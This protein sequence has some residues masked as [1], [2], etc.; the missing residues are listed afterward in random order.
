VT[1][2][3]TTNRPLL[4]SGRGVDTGLSLG[5]GRGLA[6]GRGETIGRGGGGIM[7]LGRGRG[8]PV[9]QQQ[10]EEEEEEE[11][12]QDEAQDEEVE[13]S[14][15][16]EMS[17]SQQ[18]LV[19]NNNSIDSEMDG[20][21][22]S[23]FAQALIYPLHR[24]NPER[25]VHRFFKRQSSKLV[26]LTTSKEQ[27]Q[28]AFNEPSPDDIVIS[29]GKATTSKQ[30]ENEPFKPIVKQQPKPQK[31]RKEKEEPLPEEPTTPTTPRT[32][33]PKTK[34]APP[35][36]QDTKQRINIVIIGHVDAGKSTLMGHLL[37]QSGSVDDKVI[38]KYKKESQQ[39]G[40]SSFHYAWVMD[41]NQE[42]RQ[43]GITMDVGVKHFETERKRVTILDAPGHRD[44]IPKMIT[45]AVQADLAILVVGST[46]G[47]FEAG[48]KDGGQTREHLILVRSLGVSQI[49]I[50]VNKM[51]SVD[52]SQ[53]RFDQ[54]K[55]EL[56]VFLKQIGLTDASFVPVSG[57]VGDNLYTR[58]DK[59]TW[60]DGPSLLE[61]IDAF[62]VPRDELDHQKPVRMSISDVYKSMQTG[63]TVSG[64][65][66]SGVLMVNQQVLLVP[67]KAVCNVKSITR[68][69]GN[70]VQ[71]AYTGD[72]VEVGLTSS[73]FELET[74]LSAGQILCD[75]DKPI[76]M[77]NR[78]VGRVI[79][80]DLDIPITK[81]SQV[82][83]HLQHMDV[84]AVVTKLVSTLNR[85]LEVIKKK[86]RVVTKNS[87]AI[88]ELTVVDY[89]VCIELYSDYKN[90]G[91]FMLRMGSKTVAAGIVT[92]LKKIKKA[93]AR[94]V[95]K[96][97]TTA[98]T[99]APLESKIIDD[100]QDDV[101]DDQ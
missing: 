15:D 85:Q 77:T 78:F 12:E 40:K 99:S 16:E 65:V 100:G 14:E 60:Y 45:G 71:A 33:V 86:P 3:N 64:K 79:T 69:G 19:S 83:L 75:I 50:A 34:Q 20:H 27:Q 89:P 56:L 92:E 25:F 31:G 59:V 90:F 22:P 41:Q 5:R 67:V 53:E 44:F 37:Y 2:T 87:F 70:A 74:T 51:D 39:I 61:L 21:E 42:E 11:E 101:D 66:D 46:T 80:F 32:P 73:A 47:E 35:P 57:L 8:I 91:R 6:L 10:E 68:D 23:V 76:P 4:S 52:W 13:E 82:Q 84:A 7:P 43:R 9:M 30:M 17:A 97:T 95:K 94:K 36:D 26:E 38:H 63:M 62:T 58:S 1:T 29:K 55:T 88:I 24:V 28:F 49:L 48:F 81:G 93:G 96:S 54:I 72:N 98:T 18:P